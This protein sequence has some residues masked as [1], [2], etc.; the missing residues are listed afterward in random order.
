MSST[1]EQIANI[2]ISGFLYARQ[3]IT[4]EKSILAI[5]SLCKVEGYSDKSLT[6]ESENEL[7]EYMKFG[8]IN[9]K[10]KES[11]QILLNIAISHMSVQRLKMGLY[12]LEID[13]NY[14][15][16]YQGI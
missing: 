11:K 7:I 12:V 5:L 10:I 15:W 9:S 2:D 8:L 1:T 6:K 3:R 16:A 4:S 14:D 13:E